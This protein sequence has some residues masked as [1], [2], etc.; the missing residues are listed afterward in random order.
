MLIAG[1]LIFTAAA[2][3]IGL[4]GY[5]PGDIVVSKSA[6]E[7]SAYVIL[8]K[9]DDQYLYAYIQRDCVGRWRWVWTGTKRWSDASFI[10]RHY[11]TKIAH[12]DIDTLL[13]F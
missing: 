11:S 1:I 4:G 9:R 8:D 13:A 6:P 5:Q 12:V 7:G 3:C 10:E 2:G